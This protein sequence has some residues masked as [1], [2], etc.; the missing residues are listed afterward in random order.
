MVDRSG[1]ARLFRIGHLPKRT[2]W[3]RRTGARR[4][5]TCRAFL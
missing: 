5:R 1:A 3:V 2:Q 4:P